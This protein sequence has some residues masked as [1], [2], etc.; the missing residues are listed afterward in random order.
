[1]NPF[2]SCYWKLSIVTC[3]AAVG[4]K[5]R[6]KNIP[7]YIIIGRPPPFSTG[8]EGVNTTESMHVSIL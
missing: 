3:G 6:K 5:Q 8:L 1:M 7:Q 2:Y 4:W